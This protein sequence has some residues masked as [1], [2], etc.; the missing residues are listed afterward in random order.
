MLESM[1]AARS[2]GRRSS[3]FL[4]AR[5]VEPEPGNRV[6]YPSRWWSQARKNAA[7]LVAG[8]AIIGA[9]G[10]CGDAPTE[11]EEPPPS[12]TTAEVVSAGGPIFRTL[13]VALESAAE[14][15]VD[16]WT[17]DS[18]RL[19]IASPTVSAEHR[20]FLPRLRPESRYDY[21][22]YALSEAG[23]RGQP[24]ADQFV[25][26]SLPP[27]LAALEFYTIGSP[28]HPLTLVEVRSPTWYVVVDGDGEVIW[29]WPDH[30]EADGGFTRL[31][32]GDFVFLKDQGLA[33]ISP[34]R[35]LIA[36]LLQVRAH[37]D[38]IQASSGNTVL[39]LAQDDTVVTDT[40]WAGESIW[41]WNPATGE[42]AK[43][44]T[45]FDFLSPEIDRG[46]RSR[47][48]D[49]LHGNSLAIGPRGN[50]LLSLFW[51]RQVISIAADYES[52]EWRL[53][54]PGTTLQ[55][56]DGAMAGGQHTASE[57]SPGRIL[58]FDNGADRP[59]GPIDRPE[60]TSYSRALEIELDVDAGTARVA[61]EFR[62]RPDILAPVT[63]AARRLDNGNTFV[64]FGTAPGI[65]PASAGFGAATGPIAVYEVTATNRI[66]WF[67]RVDGPANMYRATPLTS[68]AGEKA[69]R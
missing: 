46:L 40:L 34:Q 5:I 1:I 50:V 7:V 17:T 31:A 21:E 33:V 66:V 57:V 59:D 63:S 6:V 37:H 36:E 12:V 9:I 8:A 30:A 19:Q 13:E 64:T 26:D 28:T 61:W 65:P 62:P 55:V 22:V 38:V 24:Y 11:V 20:V 15:A 39:F 68:I 10:A 29:Y 41:E 16:Y 47:P 43:R 18:P 35:Q 4:D 2:D 49:W 45:S 44:W 48:T 53:G 3:T 52:L 69:V 32:N 42:L 14:I 51:L 27:E 25:T 23:V 67:M 60:G 54:G 58:V 56:E